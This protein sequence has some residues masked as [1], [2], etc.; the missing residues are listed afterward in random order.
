MPLVSGIREHHQLVRV[1]DGQC[2]EQHAVE[3]AED[4]RVRADAERER[5][6]SHRREAGG[7][8]ENANGV[9]KVLPHDVCVLPNGCGC[10]IDEGARPDRGDGASGL[11]VSVLQ[12]RSERT[13]HLP[14][15]LVAE[16]RGIAPEQRAVDVGGPHACP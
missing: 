4:R 2:L 13:R 14:A 12:L 9:A 1:A 7:G 8:G 3:Q 11:R 5:Q 16:L 15:V 6:H 10:E